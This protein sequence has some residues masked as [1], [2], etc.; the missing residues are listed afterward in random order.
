MSCDGG[1]AAGA[2]AP[3]FGFGRFSAAAGSARFFGFDFSSEGG[4]ARL[5]AIRALRP[6]FLASSRRFRLRLSS[7][8]F[9]RISV[10][11]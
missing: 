5:D 1:V 7:R 11:P 2:E 8:S 4:A 9:S 3:G 6:A 10:S